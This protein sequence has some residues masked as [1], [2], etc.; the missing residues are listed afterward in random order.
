MIDDDLVYV[1]GII[2][3]MAI[4]RSDYKTS[5]CFIH[6]IE[7][8]MLGGTFDKVNRMVLVFFSWLI[9]LLLL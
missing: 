5:W 2:L 8:V 6:E 1:K 3:A 4:F 7:H 9:F